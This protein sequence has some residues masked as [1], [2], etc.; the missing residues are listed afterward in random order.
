MAIG[1]FPV[2]SG[3]APRAGLTG[4]ELDLAQVDDA[5]TLALLYFHRWSPVDNAARP[6]TLIP[7]AFAT[8]ASDFSPPPPSFAVLSQAQQEASRTTFEL[9]SSYTNL[10]FRAAAVGDAAI[11]ISVA[12]GSRASP[13]DWNTQGDTFFGSNGVVPNSVDG[14]PRYFGTDGFLTIMHELG[15]ALGLK[16]GH[17]EITTPPTPRSEVA[18]AANVNDNEFSIMTYASYLGS[19]INPLSPVPTSAKDGSA[20]QS[21]MMYDI[22][23]LQAMYGAN[24]DKVGTTDTYRWN[25]ITGQETINNSAAPATGLSSTGKIFSTVWTQGAIAIYDLRTFG[26][27]QVDD[28]RPGHFLKFSDGQLAN[29]TSDPAIPDG[30]PGYTAQG[31]IYNALVGKRRPALADRRP[32][33]RL[34]QRHADR[35]RPRQQAH[36]QCRQRHPGH[37]TRQR[38]GERRAG[39]R[40]AL[41]RPGQQHPA[42]HGSR[43]RRRHRLRL[44][45]RRRRRA[46]RA[47]WGGEPLRHAAAGDADGGTPR[48]SC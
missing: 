15:H 6:A 35:Q 40:H 26:Q 37:R 47:P 32:H 30:T 22:A 24:F 43:P 10:S 5:N 3:A 9:V 21:F 12:D 45:P 18:L 27:D 29:L 44:R 20:P 33:H 2:P 4:G 42:R 13:P 7:Y 28:L 41:L 48:R 31:N 17:F 11:R 39:R 1:G 14:V 8:S 34:G 23:A 16:H 36:G 46:G 38:H 25:G 19:A